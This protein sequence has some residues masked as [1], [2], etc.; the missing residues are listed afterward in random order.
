MFGLYKANSDSEAKIFAQ[1]CSDHV[2]VTILFAILWRN[3]RE[4][5]FRSLTCAERCFAGVAQS[6]F[7]ATSIY[8]CDDRLD[9]EVDATICEIIIHIFPRNTYRYYL[10]QEDFHITLITFPKLESTR[11]FASEGEAHFVN[12]MCLLVHVWE[13]L[14]FFCSH[15]DW[16]QWWVR[17]DLRGLRY[18]FRITACLAHEEVLTSRFICPASY[19]P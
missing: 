19:A 18:V 17:V 8:Q 4:A 3:W 11:S 7:T 1:I 14:W 5:G 10:Y 16:W 13:M 6:R 15:R 9:P 12:H 2:T